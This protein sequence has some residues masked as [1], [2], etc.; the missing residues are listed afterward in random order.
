[1][2]LRVG[3]RAARP[4]PVRGLLLLLGLLLLPAV[5]AGASGENRSGTDPEEGDGD[6]QC[7][8]MKTTSRVHP[9]YIVS[10]EM[11]RPGPHC[12]TFQ[13]IATLKKGRKTCLD[14]DAPIYRKIIKKLMERKL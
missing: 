11:I 13:M 1:M 4:G 5:V 3:S 8:C 12:P 9:K 7:V 2:S 6:L 14:P 10:L